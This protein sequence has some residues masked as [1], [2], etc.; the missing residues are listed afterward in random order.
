MKNKKTLLISTATL[1]LLGSVLGSCTTTPK[2]PETPSLQRLIKEGRY[3]EARGLF[4]ARVDINSVD[5]DGNTALHLAAQLDEADMVSFLIIKGADTEAKNNRGDTP[6]H[7]AIKNN[8]LASTKILAIV[9]GDIFAKDADGNMA[10]ELALA[11]GGEWYKAVI[12]PQTGAIRDTDGESIVHYFVKTRDEVAMDYCISQELPLSVADNFSKTPLSLA[13]ENASDP[14]AIRIA[15]KLLLA[16]AQPVGGDYAYFEDAVRTHNSLLRFNDGQTALHIATIQG[17]TG[18]VDYI[19]KDKTSARTQDILQAQDITGA[20]P[21][22]EAVRYGRVDIAK[23]LLSN[24]AQV[25]ALDSIGKTPLLLNI[26]EKAQLDMY[27]TL[28]QYKA[29]IA[30]KDM[31][32][33]TVLHIATMAKASPEVIKVLVEAGAPVNERNK[34]GVTPLALAIDQNMDEHVVYYASL[35]ADIFAEDMKGQSPLSLALAESTPEMLQTLIT[36]QNIQ[37]KDSA[38]NTALHIAILS[39]APF[40]YIKYL[41]NSGADVNA[42]N[43]SG[44]SVLYLTVEKN[45]RQTGELLLERGADIFATNINNYSPLRLALENGGDVQDWLITSQTLNT[46]DGSGN[47]PLHYAAEWALDTAL[48][49][50]I[51]KGAKLDAVNANGESVLFAAVKGGSTKCLAILVDNGAETDTRSNLARDH[52]GNTPLHA[53]VRWNAEAI[54]RE[55]IALG[56]EVNAQNMSGKTALGDACRAGKT[57]MALLLLA[58][59]ADVNAT[60]ATGRSILVD[61]IQGNNEQMVAMLLEKGANPNIQ[62][63]SG[64]NA[65][66]EAALSRNARIITLIRNA[67][68]NPLARDS[69]GE[70]PFSLILRSGNEQLMKTVL[71]SNTTIVDSDGNTPVH[72]AVERKVPAKTLT[73]LLSMGYP[74]SQRNGKGVTALY[75]A[76]TTKQ[77]SLVEILLEKGADPFIATTTNES[78]LSVALKEKNIKILDAIAKYC[79]TA[80]DMKGDSIL[81]YAARIADADTV[82]HLVS[83]GLN[84]NAKNI[85]GETP[86]AM[87]ARWQRPAVAEVLR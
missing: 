38:G 9:H 31:F 84:V 40:D 87:A 7:V 76:V 6:L 18:I 15:A 55:L 51:E 4:A 79:A 66:H 83:L 60:D 41:V 54:A 64:R 13:F 80:T 58:H 3:D 37:S 48:K 21:L 56:V 44:D 70:T 86:G 68:G 22:H 47:T 2:E 25:D 12:T 8:C 43:K 82:S 26:P 45:K 46:T 53:A 59:G 61:S 5:E 62:E 19:L 72:I 29:N 33:D 50:L 28:V 49:G 67:G 23:L 69:I 65:Y 36:R 10:L 73:T 16:G 74:A 24:G 52:V 34:Q 27:K 14:A 30:Q 85:S 32:G 71:G 20:T 78:A 11:K 39:D 77:L 81:H 35:G 57:D 17:D 75:T 42:R 1:V 63:I